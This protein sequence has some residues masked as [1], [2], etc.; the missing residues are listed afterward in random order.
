[1]FLVVEKQSNDI[2]QNIMSNDREHTIINISKNIQTT[3]ALIPTQLSPFE[4]YLA[5]YFFV[6]FSGG[7]MNFRVF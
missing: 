6:H 3:R 4:I 1:M 7:R 2:A 5:S